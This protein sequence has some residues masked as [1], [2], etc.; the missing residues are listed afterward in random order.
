MFVL[1]LLYYHSLW[2]FN[3]LAFYVTIHYKLY[4]YYYA[5]IVHS[6]RVSEFYE[7]LSLCDGDNT[8][9][10]LFIY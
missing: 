1:Y 7:N 4:N 3:L 8:L 2:D 10:Y 5:D 6:L 9:I